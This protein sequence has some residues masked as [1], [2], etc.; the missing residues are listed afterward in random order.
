[1]K[2]NIIFSTDAEKV[3]KNKEHHDEPVS[4]LGTPLQTDRW[5]YRIVVSALA[6]TLISSIGGAVWLQANDK[7]I[8]E[9]LIGLGTGALG[10]LAG[11]LA[12]TPSKE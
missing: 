5:I 6:L 8:P 9:I 2:R 10:G 7:D 4:G 11:L 3:E 1:M 12:P